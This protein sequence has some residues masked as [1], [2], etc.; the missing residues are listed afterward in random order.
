M[1]FPNNQNYNNN[2]YINQSPYMNNNKRPST[3]TE[4]NNSTDPQND[5]T[6]KIDDVSISKDGNSVDIKN[7]IDEIENK[8][9]IHR[10]STSNDLGI[11]GE[12]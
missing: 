11:I 3:A 7:F 4:V 1:N 10:I 6:M 12:V 8:N 9:T 5:K 2:D